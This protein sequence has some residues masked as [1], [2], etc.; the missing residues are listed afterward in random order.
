MDCRR[1]I[2]G[3]R[4]GRAWEAE[5]VFL[6]LS[7][8]VGWCLRASATLQSCGEGVGR[9]GEWERIL[10]SVL[11]V[12]S[13]ILAT[14]AE[15]PQPLLPGQRPGVTVRLPVLEESWANQDSLAPASA[16]THS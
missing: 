10:S 12:T 5:S 6:S 7:L 4:Q 2:N 15:G 16:A 13:P 14:S 8:A 9:G 11:K 3:G 1:G